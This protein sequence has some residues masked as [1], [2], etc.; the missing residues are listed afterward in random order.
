MQVLPVSRPQRLGQSRRFDQRTHRRTPPRWG[1]VRF[2][3]LFWNIASR[4]SAAA[5]ENDMRGVLSGEP[6]PL[7]DQGGAS[8]VASDRR[9]A[10][11]V[12]LPLPF[13]A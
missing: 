9:T 12:V 10:A 13:S 5:I 6:A 11:R 8:P 7:H 1:T 3:A 2:H 4:R